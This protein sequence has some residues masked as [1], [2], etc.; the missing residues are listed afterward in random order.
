MNKNTVLNSEFQLKMNQA[1]S[2]LQEPD[3]L[4]QQTELTGFKEFTR[5]FDTHRNVSLVSVNPELAQAINY[6]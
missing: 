2:M 3:S 6:V 4:D 1:L 5:I